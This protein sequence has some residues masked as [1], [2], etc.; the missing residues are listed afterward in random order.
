MS[1]H[2]IL[3]PSSAHRWAVCPGAPA[4]EH[5]L[6][7]PGSKY[8][9]E[10][11]AAHFLASE[12]LT[13]GV[14]ASHHL[15]RDIA[16]GADGAR[17]GLPAE[18]ES[19]FRVDS[20]MIRHVHVYLSLVRDYAAKGTLF[21][22]QALPLG[23]I[24]GEEGAEGTGDAIVLLDDEII[25]IDL[26]YGQGNEVTAE[27]NS[28]LKL[29]GLGALYRYG[30]L[31]DFKRVRLVIIQP[32][33]S[34]APN[35]WDLLVEALETWGLEAAARA[36]TA[37]TALEFRQNWIGNDHSYL[38]PGVEQC[39]WCK[40]KATC[41]ALTQQII[42]TVG[43]QFEDIPP[44][45]EIAVEM[46]AVGSDELGAKLSSVDLIEDWC[47]A[48][49][50]EVERR[51]L[52]GTPVTGYKLVQ[53]KRGNRSWI[54][55]EE[56]ER[57]LKGMRL[58]SELKLEEDPIY[59]YSLVSPTVIEKLLKEASPKRWARLQPLIGQSEGKPSVAPMSD[60]R[61]ALVR[62]ADQFDDVPTAEDFV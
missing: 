59:S 57:V 36:K 49:R 62:G 30:L 19:V 24:T 14:Q 6:H 61:P 44:A 58:K 25:V 8:A 13:G 40:A 32:R 33:I 2:A 15:G 28:Q 9:D 41:P 46:V 17:W 52:A 39:K 60:K 5:G 34:T 26:K 16:V 37:L 11:T 42:E 3:S 29:Y 45:A 31:G 10:G 23:H 12:C 47:K 35:E 20:D 51:L 48:V 54:D 4:M 22:E 53:G 43:A 1:K 50:A 55:K 56:A 27:E 38:N 18:G 7:D 21:V